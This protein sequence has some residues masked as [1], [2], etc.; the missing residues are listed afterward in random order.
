MY[1]TFVLPTNDRSGGV[2]VTVEMG[3]NLINL[4][5]TVRI[6]YK[7]SEFKIKDSLNKL[8]T[9]TNTSWFNNFNGAI[10]KYVDL[11]NIN[12]HSNEIVIAVGTFTI[13]DVYDI[14]RDDIIKLRYCH[15]F[16]EHLQE[17][18]EKVWRLPMKTLSVSER[19]LPRL[20]EYND[21]DILG[22]IPNGINTSEYFV[23]DKIR[24]NGI[25]TIYHRSPKKAPEDIIKILQSIKN[26]WPSLPQY[27]FSANKCPNGISRKSF[28][29]F[30]SIKQSRKL[31]NSSKIWFVASKSEGFGLPILEAMACG[32]VV[33]STDHDSARGLIEDGVN[34]LLVPIGDINTFIDK[35]DYLLNNDEKREELVQNGFKTVHDYSWE[36]AVNKLEGILKQ[37]I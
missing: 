35:F 36:N 2:R 5:H 12:F 13:Q 33:V 11:N 22:V 27:V 31:Y 21:K 9:S 3:N 8:L 25:G 37:L 1:I 14:D 6:V 17:I 34:G 30:P 18:T 7:S 20:K 15:G 26:K 28:W 32:A 24:K 4:G 16:S 19:L 23:E 10:E 29:R